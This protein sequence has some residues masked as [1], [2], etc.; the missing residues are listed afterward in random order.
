MLIGVFKS[1]QKIINGVTVLLLSLLWIPA[2]FLDADLYGFSLTGLRWMDLVLM[3]F[4]LACQAIY[5][6]YLVS[7]YKLVKD[8]C[9]LTSL[10][11]VILNSCYI[12]MF[13]FNLVVLANTITLLA[14]HQLLRMYGTK[15]NF[16]LSFGAGL[17]IGIVGLIYPPLFIYFIL[18]WVFLVYTTTPT[19]RDFIVSL[20]GFSVPLV[21]YIVYEFVLG[22]LSTI[23]LENNLNKIFIVNWMNLNISNKLFLTGLFFVLIF[24]L[25]NLVVT[26]GNS[27]VKISRLLVMVVL[28]FVL[29]LGSLFL[30]QFDFLASFLIVSIPLAIIIANFFQNMKKVW[31]AEI[32]FSFLLVTIII[33]YFS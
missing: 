29:G 26:I 24:S 32:L 1:N 11:F 17:L 6:N 18:L 31:L 10:V 13:E 33:G 25:L 21:Y 15:N 2:F 27:G 16:S 8:N 20:L 7:E 30:N 12:L 14:M 23:T 9:H 5:L 4:I 22:D 19:W 3:I 28:M